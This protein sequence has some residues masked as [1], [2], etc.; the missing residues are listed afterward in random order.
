MHLYAMLIAKNTLQQ[1][2]K[3]VE[4]LGKAFAIKKT[5]YNAYNVENQ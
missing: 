5:L 4:K 1:K 2:K 3:R